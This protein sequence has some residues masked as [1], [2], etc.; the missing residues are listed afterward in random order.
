MTQD[1][2]FLPLEYRTK[3]QPSCKTWWVQA[4]LLLHPSF[5]GGFSFQWDSSVPLAIGSF[6]PPPESGLV[7]WPTER[8]GSDTA[9][10]E[11]PASELR[12]ALLHSTESFWPP[13]DQAPASLLNGNRC[14]A[15]A[16]HLLPHRSDIPPIEAELPTLKEA[17]QMRSHCPMGRV[18]TEIKTAA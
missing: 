3:A 17:A 11:P 1:R 4:C 5:V 7:L 18:Q 12:A 16:P 10:L 8:D 14:V 15:Q 6:T 9:N 2:N 13:C